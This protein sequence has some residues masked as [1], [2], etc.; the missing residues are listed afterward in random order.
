MDSIQTITDYINGQ[1]PT[2]YA[3]RYMVPK[4]LTLGLSYGQLSVE[5][6][7][8]S[9]LQVERSCESCGLLTYTAFAMHMPC[10]ACAVT[11][12][13]SADTQALN[14]LPADL[15]S[16]CTSGP[17]LAYVTLTAF[18]HAVSEC[19]VRKFRQLLTAA[20]E[21]TSYVLQPDIIKLARS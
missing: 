10:I 2:G 20:V 19:N 17:A 16:L 3:T 8:N 11:G 9:A 4:T 15:S 12:F 7:G 1:T 18:L 6:P 14:V 21:H 5:W 13:G